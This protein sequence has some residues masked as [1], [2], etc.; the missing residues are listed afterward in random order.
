LNLHLLELTGQ[1]KYALEAE[2]AVFNA[3]LAAQYGAGGIEWCYYTRANQDSRPYNDKFHCCASSGPRALEMFAHYLIGEV[4]GGIS[5]T[6]MVPCSA[7]LPDSLGGAEITVTGD[8]PHS[9]SIG[10]RFEEAKG[11]EF[12]LE[13]RD[14]AD[15]RLVSV[16]INGRNVAV[17]KN[18]RGYYQISRAWKT[19]DQVAIEFEFELNS[20]VET[21]KDG[22]SWVAFTYGPWALAQTT[23]KDAIAEP[24]VGKDIL[25]AAASQRL[26]PCAPHEGAAPRF[27]IKNTDILLGPFYSAASKET[28]ARTY[29]RTR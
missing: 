19:G 11:K 4:D 26:E 14:P 6:S 8:Y 12:A 24:F 10:I 17:K 16:Q 9:S 15:S 7:V 27:R 21:P 23:D 2:R 18:D 3:L 22:E 1:A 28:G 20:Y 5:L 13:F 25:P 29:F